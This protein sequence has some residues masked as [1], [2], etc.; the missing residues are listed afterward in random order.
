MM[1]KL[2]KIFT[3]TSII[4]LELLLVIF[5]YYIFTFVHKEKLAKIKIPHKN[6]TIEIYYVDSGALSDNV[7]QVKKVHSIFNS[8]IIKNITGFKTLKSWK[9]LNSKTLELIVGFP[10]SMYSTRQ[11]TVL[12]KF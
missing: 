1:K 2:I 12:V 5:I 9:I 8:E 10:K 6:Y 11:D 7:I 3:I 4:I